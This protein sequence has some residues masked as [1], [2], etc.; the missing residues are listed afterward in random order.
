M[1]Y[2]NFN[3][4]SKASNRRKRLKYK[5]GISLENYD[6]LLKEQEEKC[7]ICGNKTELV[8]DHCHKSSRVRGLLCN[9]CNTGLGCFKDNPESLLKAIEY[10]S[11]ESGVQFPV[12]TPK[13]AYVV[14]IEPDDVKDILREE[15]GIDLS[16]LSAP[17]YY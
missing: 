9:Q 13:A 1:S 11:N 7:K 10:L 8:V 17:D 16:R 5:Y 2:R 15:T 3:Y 14:Y 6:W 12:S 4:S